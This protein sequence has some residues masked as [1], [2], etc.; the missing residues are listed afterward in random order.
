MS[1]ESRVAR[2]EYLVQLALSRGASAIANGDITFAQRFT[3]ASPSPVLVGAPLAPPGFVWE[4]AAVLIEDTFDDPAATLALGLDG[5]PSFF[6]TT[7][8]IDTQN[9]ATYAND[10]LEHPLAGTAGQAELTIVPGT[11]TQGSGIVLL[12]AKR[13]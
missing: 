5:F 1:L 11:S 9:A 10:E 13:L 6:L 8:Q 3:F 7:A 2:L 12:K 4:R